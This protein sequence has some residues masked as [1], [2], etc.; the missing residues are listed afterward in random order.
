MKRYKQ[1]I[2]IIKKSLSS[3][4]SCIDTRYAVQECYGDD[5]SMFAA[6]GTDVDVNITDKNDNNDDDGVEMLSNLIQS[7]LEN[8][9]EIFVHNELQ[10]ILSKQNTEFKLD[11]LD[12]VINDFLLNQKVKEEEEQLDIQSARD[13]VD[14]ADLFLSSSSTALSSSNTISNNLNTKV[15]D[16]IS[17]QSYH[18]KLELKKKL[19]AELE[20]AEREKDDLLHQIEIEKRHIGKVFNGIEND[21]ANPL[22]KNADICCSFNGM[23]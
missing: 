2:N 11:L 21:I 10:K 7:I 19:V 18:L 8:I 1:L 17:Y 3:S 20:R 15:N 23:G 9:N 14:R 4:S 22:N 16:L 13:A 6:V 5:I 12:R